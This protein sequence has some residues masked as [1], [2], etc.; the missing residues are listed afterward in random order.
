[1]N[2]TEFSFILL[3][4]C[5]FWIVAPVKLLQLTLIAGVF[6]AAAG[7][8]IGSVGLQPGL[9]PALVFIAYMVLQVL[10]GA[11]FASM[12]E[13]IRGTRPFVAVTA[14][15]LLSSFIM[16]RLFEG[17]VQVWPQKSE[18][19]FMLTPLAPSSS[20]INQD[21]YLL[22]NCLFFVAGTLFLTRSGTS[23][24]LFLRTYLYSGFVVAGVSVWQFA[25]RM[26]GIPFPEGL[27]YS[28]PGWAILTEQSMGAIP[29]INGPFSEPSALGGYM[30]AIVCATGWLLLQGHRDR[31]LPRLLI[32]ALVTMLIST[33]ATGIAL[34]G[35]IAVGVPTY[36]LVTASRSL[37]V[38]VA[39]IGVPLLLICSTILV[40]ASMFSPKFN[41][42]IG[43][44]IDATINKQQSES[45]DA[46]T[47]TDVDSLAVSIDTYGLGAG[48]GSNRSSS[49]VPGLLSSIGIPGCVALIWFAATLT[50]RVR[51]S[52]RATCS[53]EQLFVID[54][55]CGAIVG[56]ILSAL[57]SGPTITAV[58][59][60]FLLA[61]L[62]ASTI[63]V[64]AQTRAARGATSC[65]SRELASRP[66]MPARAARAPIMKQA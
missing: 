49:L 55:C 2:V 47:S 45:Y 65:R 32:V 13:V 22:I 9:L 19:P 1:M 37:L 10:L 44:V 60:Y 54:G 52:R 64:A 39:K 36:A 12:P 41:D 59:F 51:M 56:F 5:L 33:S 4:L 35:L 8:T 27:F 11:R 30:G 21:L 53:K 25:S 17:V 3:P 63:H 28:N 57:I 18:P 58:S 7:L 61:L 34:L 43:Q 40:G 66:Q 20:N 15:A 26:A 48:W 14:Y 29:R 6:E 38:G 42:A 50:R 24:I 46:R 16:P 23:L 62:L 31:I